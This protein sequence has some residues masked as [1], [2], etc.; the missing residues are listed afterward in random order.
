SKAQ[1]DYIKEV[2]ASKNIILKN[3]P[4]LVDQIWA[5]RPS[6]PNFLIDIHPLEYS[7][8]TTAS[9]ILKVENKIAS[10]KADYYL[11]SS[12][13]EIAWLFNIRSQDVDFTP[14]V[15]AY[16]LVGL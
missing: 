15:T 1:M 9:K 7:G 14:L 16:A 13:D 12:L 10:T 3:T 11:F 6:L 5:D 8:E 2:S 4:N